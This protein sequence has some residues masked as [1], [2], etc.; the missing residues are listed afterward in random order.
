MFFL[1]IAINREQICRNLFLA[2]HTHSKDLLGIDTALC[3]DFFSDREELFCRLAA[4]TMSDR[5]AITTVKREI[6]QSK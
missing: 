5:P 2:Y 4:F 1:C 6:C 3:A